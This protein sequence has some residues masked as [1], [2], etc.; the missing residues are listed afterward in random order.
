MEGPAVM[1]MPPAQDPSEGSVHSIRTVVAMA[2]MSIILPA[3]PEAS[4]LVGPA[5]KIL[6]VVVPDAKVVGDGVVTRD[7][8]EIRPFWAAARVA[9]PRA[10]A[11]KVEVRMIVVVRTKVLVR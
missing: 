1:V 8:A 3:R 4:R 2:L 9:M 7:E 10:D 11:A 6:M 5:S